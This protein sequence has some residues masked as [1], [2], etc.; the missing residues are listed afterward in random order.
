[1]FKTIQKTV[2]VSDDSRK[3]VTSGVARGAVGGVLLG[4]VGLGPVGV[5]AGA[6]SAKNKKTTTFLIIYTDG[7]RKTV[8][9]K[10]NS[11][12]FKKYVK[13]LDV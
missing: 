9:V 13:Y 11:S 6:M 3:S 10:T 1:M 2:I 5:V 12:D 8:T 4:A 7:S